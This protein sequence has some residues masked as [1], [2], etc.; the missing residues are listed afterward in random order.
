M[1]GGPEL[2][3]VFGLLLPVGAL[4]AIVVAIVIALGRRK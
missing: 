3:I 1:P 2:F 4:V